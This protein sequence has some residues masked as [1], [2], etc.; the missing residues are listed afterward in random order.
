[1]WI[2]PISLLQNHPS[3][4]ALSEYALDKSATDPAFQVTL[5]SLLGPAAL[6]Q[7]PSPNHVGLVLCERLINMPVQVIPPMYHMLAN[8]LKWAID[9]VRLF[10]QV[11][12]TMS[13]YRSTPGR[14]LRIHSPPLH[15]PYIPPL[16]R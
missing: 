3:I 15:L 7:N 11:A 16:A 4:K 8:E 13:S 1:M 2:I 10:L 6:A 14:A 5:Q 12:S 9:D